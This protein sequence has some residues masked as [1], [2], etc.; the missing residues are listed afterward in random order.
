MFFFLLFRFFSDELIPFRISKKFHFFCDRPI[1]SLSLSLSLSLCLSRVDLYITM[2]SSKS[3]NFESAEVASIDTVTFLTNSRSHN[4]LKTVE[5]QFH[6]CESQ[7]HDYQYNVTKNVR[8]VVSKISVA[9][10]YVESNSLPCYR[11]VSCSLLAL[12]F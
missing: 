9:D 3:K 5:K 4:W 1:S 8:S 12:A 6:R 7:S 11:T 10:R 2:G